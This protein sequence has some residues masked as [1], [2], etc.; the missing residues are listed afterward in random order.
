MFGNK[1][2]RGQQDAGQAAVLVLIMLIAIVL[3]VLLVPGPVREDLLRD[4]DTETTTP[5]STTT[6]TT[7][8][9]LLEEHPGT[10]Y[11]ISQREFT[12]DIPSF[13]LFKTTDSEELKRVNPFYIS[14]TLFGRRTRKITFELANPELTHNV[15]LSFAVSNPKGILM[16]AL[17]NNLIFESKLQNYNVEPVMLDP[18]FLGKTNVLEFSVSGVGGQFWDKN[19][20]SIENLRIIADITDISRRE[21]SSTFLV[22]KTEKENAEKLFIKF[23]P[24]CEPTAVGNLY[25][26][27][28]DKTVFSGVPDCG[29][30]NVHELSPNAL[31]EGENALSFRT[32]K[33]SYLVDLITIETKLKENPAPVYYFELSED[34]YKKAI[35]DEYKLNLTLEFVDDKEFKDG[36]VT[37]NGKD[38]SIYTKERIWAKTIDPF[39]QLGQNSLKLTPKDTMEIVS[40]KLTLRK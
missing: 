25:V 4:N 5:G 12:H 9:I 23:N 18:E 30:L 24:N 6:T 19:E 15:M 8:N 3:Y 17:N 22:T 7:Q 14:T 38:A 31:I 16:I 20:Y 29:I 34:N 26:D 33:G 21:T 40:L 27:I 32:D 11:I 37:I 13:N 28:N 36:T 10:I 39:I 1:G 2:K 35:R